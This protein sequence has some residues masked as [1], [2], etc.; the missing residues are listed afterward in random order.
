MSSKRTGE[1]YSTMSKG[2]SKADELKETM[3]RDPKEGKV[4]QSDPVANYM[5]PD[6]APFMCAHC[7]YFKGPNSCEKVNGY[8]DPNGCCNLFEADED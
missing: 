6:K 7:E 1:G 5:G 4:E 2:Q 8:I 3:L